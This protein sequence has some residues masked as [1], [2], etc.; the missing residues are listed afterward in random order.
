MALKLNLDHVCNL[1][2]QNKYT[3]VRIYQGHL[4]DAELKGKRAFEKIDGNG[5]WE[6]ASLRVTEIS[7]LFG[8]NWTM[9]FNDK[10]QTKNLT[11]MTVCQVSF[12]EVTSPLQKLDGAQ[13][14][15]T[16]QLDVATLKAQLLEELKA[17][18]RAKDQEEEI[19]ELRRE[20]EEMQ[21]MSGKASMFFSQ[22][23]MQFIPMGESAPVTMQDAD[24]EH[25]QC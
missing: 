12:P 23:L 5:S 24:I 17:D 20:R 22:L 13:A 10:S 18:M 11:A 9:L 14:A 21:T 3:I 4:T 15:P 8:G 25:Q 2:E 1:I 7:K 19:A 6:V 16:G